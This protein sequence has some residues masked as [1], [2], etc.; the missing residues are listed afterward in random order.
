M[1]SLPSIARAG[2]WLAGGI[3]LAL[4]ADRAWVA[5]SDPARGVETRRTTAQ[6]HAMVDSQIELRG[7]RDPRVLAAMRDVPRHEFVP[8]EWAHLAYS[9]RPLPIG[10]E[11]TI[12]QPYIVALMSEALHLRGDEV[13][14]EVGT[15]SGYQAAVLGE[16]AAQVYTIE[17][18]PE[19]AASARVVLERLDYTN[20]HVRAGDGYR[21]WPEHAPFD[22]IMVTAAPERI[23][24]PLLE[25]LKPGGR[26]VLP[27]G[28]NVQDLV[29]VTRTE[30]GFASD[31]LA[32]V[33]F[34]PMTG[35]V[36]KER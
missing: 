35:E 21:G 25:Q 4:G 2:V 3:V 36:Q 8:E 17:I 29:R 5:V 7:V 9:D 16:L 18:V 24:E 11:Q 26:L 13:V 12:S 1:K 20:V 22:A 27:V 10:Y 28:Q 6:R 19:L 33:R 30:D 14:L 32:A 23:P 34:V 31:T 15:G